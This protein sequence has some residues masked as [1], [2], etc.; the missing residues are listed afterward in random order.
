M[1][2]VAILLLVRVVEMQNVDKP[3]IS[4]LYLSRLQWLLTSKTLREKLWLQWLCC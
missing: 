1:V 3:R 4:S 2:S